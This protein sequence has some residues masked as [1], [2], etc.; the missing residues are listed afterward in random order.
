M[1]HKFTEYV[2]VHLCGND[3]TEEYGTKNSSMGQGTP[4]HNFLQM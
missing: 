4:H 2:Q 1:I 3:L